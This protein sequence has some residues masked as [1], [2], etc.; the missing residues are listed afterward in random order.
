[1]FVLNKYIYICLRLFKCPL[2]VHFKT[3]GDIEL[4]RLVT[5]GFKWFMTVRYNKKDTHYNFWSD[6]KLQFRFCLARA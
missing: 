1:M 6:Q 3:F 5:M 2:N 4:S